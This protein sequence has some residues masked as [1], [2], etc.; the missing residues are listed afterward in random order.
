MSISTNKVNNRKGFTLVEVV[1]S[2]VILGLVAVPLTEIFH[3]GLRTL[4]ER[5][6]EYIITSKLRSMMEQ[7][8]STDYQF[9]SSGS[10]QVTIRGKTEWMNLTVTPWDI[11]GDFVPESGVKRIQVEWGGRTL[12]TIVT[13]HFGDV[14]KIP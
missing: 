7:L 11:D 8:L 5:M 3:T 10:I 12:S 2:A 13:D 9:L 4:D 1:L 14:E 6:D